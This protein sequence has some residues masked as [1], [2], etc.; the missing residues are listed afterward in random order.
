M[1]YMFAHQICLECSFWFVVIFAVVSVC[2]LVSVWSFKFFTS[3][4][5]KNILGDGEESLLKTYKKNKQTN[6]NKCFIK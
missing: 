6:E 1:F 5:S 3:S 2:G 4:Q